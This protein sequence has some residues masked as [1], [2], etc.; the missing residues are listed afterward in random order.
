MT[1]H[2]H[3]NR[4]SREKSPYLLQ[5]AHNPVDWYPWSEEAFEKAKKEDKPIFLSVGYSTCHW[6][7]V[8]EKESFESEQVAKVMNEYFVKWVFIRCECAVILVCG[9][10]NARHISDCGLVGRELCVWWN[11]DILLN[12]GKAGEP[13]WK[14]YCRN[15]VAVHQHWDFA[16]KDARCVVTGR[17]RCRIRWRKKLLGIRTAWK[18]Q[19]V[20]SRSYQDAKSDNI[21]IWK[22]EQVY[23]KTWPKIDF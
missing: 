21:C 1:S 20:W 22:T 2:P 8:M 23:W 7:H 6:C 16:L 3:T 13:V 15:W 10:G 12:F 17:R 14:R 11:D 19:G 9:C 4:L 18:D 5:H